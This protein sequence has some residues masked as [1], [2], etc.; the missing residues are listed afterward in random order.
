MLMIRCPWCGT[1]SEDEFTYGGQ[2]HIARPFT[3]PDVSDQVWADYLYV[4]S[5]PKGIHHER[6]H[7][8]YGCR[9]W[10]HIARDTVTHEVKAV[11]RLR[12]PLLQFGGDDQ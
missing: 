2:A 12:D 4:R 6:W 11:Y 3:S 7:H 8:T 1:R 5:N 10:F 9:Q